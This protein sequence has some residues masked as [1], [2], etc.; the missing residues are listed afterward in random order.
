[1]FRQEY[2]LLSYYL[3]LFALRNGLDLQQIRRIVQNAIASKPALL[4]E[5]NAAFSDDSVS[6]RQVLD[7]PQLGEIYPT[8]SEDLARAYARQMLLIQGESQFPKP[9]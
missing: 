8:D 9:V 7:D 6:W 1:M 2:P 4:D 3:S 5:I